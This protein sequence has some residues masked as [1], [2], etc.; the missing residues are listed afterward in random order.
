MKQVKFRAWEKSS[1]EMI[2]VYDIDFAGGIINFNTAWRG[3]EE[4]ELM[5]YTG[6]KD[7]NGKE[8]YEGDIIKFNHS[9][10][11]YVVIVQNIEADGAKLINITKDEFNKQ[12]YKQ[13]L[14][15][16]LYHKYFTLVDA[17]NPEIIG[18]I[19]ENLDLLK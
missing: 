5:Q 2:E 17:F 3:L 16:H 7:K 14:Y 6:L 8:I 13:L 18:N 4:V 19:Y 1:K 9:G 10:Y 12:N 11:P 15:N